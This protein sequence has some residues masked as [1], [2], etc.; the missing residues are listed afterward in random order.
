MADK[1]QIRLLGGF[2]ASLGD[3]KP[4]ALKGRKTQALLAVLAVSPGTAL[5]REKLTNILWSDRGDEQARGSLR[6]ALA[7][8]RRALGEDDSLYVVADRDSVM[9][10][11]KHL[12]CDVVKL[13]QLVGIGT[14]GNLEQASELY[15]GDLLDGIGVTDPS[16][17]DW[18]TGER[19]RLSELTQR[20]M[21]GLLEKQTE[22]GEGDKAVSTARRLLALDPLQEQ[23]HR[24]LM[25]LYIDQGDRSMALKQYQ[26][27]REVLKA[28]LGIE[29][30]AETQTLH[31]E[32]RQGGD[33]P[34][35]AMPDKPPR[36]ELTLPEKPSIAVLPFVNMS[37]DAEQEYFADG[38]TEDITTELSRFHS[39][40]V[41]ARN[42]SF[43]YKGQSINVSKIG[44]ELG[45][46][47]IVEGSVRKAGKRI[48]VS[49]QLVEAVTGNHVWAERYDRDLGDIFAVQDELVRTI[50][51]TIGGRV[52][53]V[54]QVRAE[55]LSEAGLLAYDHVLRA[56]AAI[57]RF[58]KEDNR[59]AREHLEKAIE[60]D[61]R[62]PQAHRWLAEVLVM[63]WMAHWVKDRAAAL[64][65]AFESAKR[66]VALDESFSEALATLGSI[67]VYR[68][69]FEDAKQSLDR[70]IELNPNDTQ[71]LDIYGIY[72]IAVGRAD[73][74]VAQYE[75][76]ARINP[77]HPDW[78]EWLKGIAFFTARRYDEAIATLRTIKDPVN[79]VRGWLAVSYAGAGRLDEARATLEE[80]LCVAE[81]DMA[82][83]PGRKLAAWEDYWHGAL[84]YQNEADF[85][86][87]YDALRKAGMED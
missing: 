20:A 29:P 31:E 40:F 50:T 59:H 24:A 13:E 15:R 75:L 70:A 55:H 62:S 86:H 58:N 81:E 54:G 66:A 21:N 51:A 19:A 27:C 9:L 4:L 57:L 38:I 44:R 48:R 49:A 71:S 23:V 34:I 61:P 67:Q 76:S 18:L 74:A 83:F 39:L 53:S 26:A 22:A 7:E 64:I 80:F 1:L 72:L 60:L 43:A 77:L 5:S 78:F 6:Q 69:E 52:D 35:T 63:D 41:I 42:S 36:E 82:I 25:R 3:G 79:E 32:I 87:L 46:A 17:E 37:G 14:V 56:N 10:E 12:D 65:S 33:A 8:L 30:E 84:E 73:E 28:E 85:E 47:Y 11:T 16:F 45:V 68:R 2:E